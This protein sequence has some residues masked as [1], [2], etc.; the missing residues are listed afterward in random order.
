MRH[1][2]IK[3]NPLEKSQ[4]KDF[5]VDHLLDMKKKES[6][7][8]QQ[9]TNGFMTMKFLGYY[10]K[11]GSNNKLRSFILVMITAFHAYVVQHNIALV[12]Y[13]VCYLQVK[14]HKIRSAWKLFY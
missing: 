8:A 5:K 6:E 2:S 10:E 9:S 14:N 4:R 12:C 13:N 3:A 11:K 7:L 1:R